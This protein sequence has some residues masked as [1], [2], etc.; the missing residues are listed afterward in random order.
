[1]PQKIPKN[2]KKNFINILYLILNNKNNG[3]KP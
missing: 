2:L 1:M 3:K